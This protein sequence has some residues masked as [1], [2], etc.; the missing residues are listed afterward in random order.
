MTRVPLGLMLALWTVAVLPSAA[1]MVAGAG[2]PGYARTFRLPPKPPTAYEAHVVKCS[3]PGSVLWPGEPLSLTVQVIN[4]GEAPLTAGRIDVIAYGTKGQPGDVW[5]P[6]VFKIADA[7]SVPLKVSVA[8][9]GFQNVSVIVPIPARFGGYA[10]VLD[11]GARGRL[12]LTSVVRT[13]KATQGRVQYPKFCLDALPVDVLKRLDVHAIRYGEGYKPTTDKDY[14]EWYAREGRKLKD[15]NDA[16]IAVLFMVGGGD[17]FHPNQPLGRPRPWL[18]GNGVMLDTKFDLAWLPSYDDDFQQWCRQFARDWGW[19]RGPIN[20]F[21]LWNEP[22]EGISIS[23][24]G[25]DMLRYRELYTHMFQGVDQA[26]QADGVQ[27]LVGGCDSSSNAMDKLFP[28]GTNAFLPMFDF[29]SIH[30]QGLDSMATVKDWVDRKGYGGRVKIWDTESWVANTDDRVAAVVAGDRAAGYDRAMGVFGGNIVSGDNYW[31]KVKVFGADGK[32]TEINALTT[33]STA[34]AVGASQHFVGERTFQRLLFPNGLPWVM[35]FN[36]LANNPEDGTV[37]V[38]GD[39]GEEF[40]ADHLP[41]RTARGFAE[42]RHKA[43]L[44]KQWAALPATAT[45]ERRTALQKQ[46]DMPETLNGATMSVSADPAFHLYDFYGNAVPAQNGKIVVPLD[47]RGFFLRADGRPGSF[48][49]LTRALQTAHIDGIEPVAIVAHDMTAP[50]EQHPAVRLSITN[51]LNR[52]VRGFLFTELG[53]FGNPRLGKGMQRLTIAP[54]HTQEVDLPVVSG[55]SESSNTY[56]LFARFVAGTKEYATLQ[57]NIHC[58]VIARKTIVVDGKLDDWQGVLPQT[59]TAGAASRTLTEAAWFPF[60]TFD[61]G[62]GQ[63][64]AT[65]YLAYD[66]QNFY[67]AAKVADAT[68]DPGMVRFATRDDDAYFYPAV[69]RVVRLKSPGTAPVRDSDTDTPQDL[70]W[71]AGVR[72]Y[73]YRRDPEL[74]SG[75]T[76]AHDNVQIAFNV[77]PQSEKPW[78]PHPP[79]VMFGFT[80]YKDTDYEYALNPVA[81]QYGGGTEIWRMAAPGMPHKHFY[82]RQP[83]SPRDG[84]VSD[85]KLVVTRDGNTRLVEASIP[86]TE[87][88]DVKK[89]LDARQT[90]KFSFRVNDDKGTG[91]MELSRG[92]SVA[93]RNGSFHSDWIEHWANEIEFGWGK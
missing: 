89:R 83:K 45:E 16:N 11:L 50:I 58:N 5:T 37:V 31:E 67:F 68:P 77:L 1:Q 88:P 7:G 44:R 54:N 34:A 55:R 66:D 10:L 70:T 46:I 19:P 61:V 53:A 57:E 23:G 52:P 84:P 29:L 14:A 12:F 26:R 8:A 21:S 92:R 3:A 78:Y 27:V 42:R 86:W 24:W 40:G 2:M 72:R 43:A 90:V 20:A 87:L 65:G 73:S 15:Y 59:V 64:F 74:P 60:K 76:P 4:K 32:P 56:R 49:R 81:P 63:G 75:N 33:W 35:L 85:G 48:A 82:P 80:H 79:G 91:T 28:D 30:Y 18:D 13:F 36:G 93:K 22:W 69:S 25:A 62:V 6:H 47:G 41:Y 38:V 71:P 9:N 17:F 39:L 51:V